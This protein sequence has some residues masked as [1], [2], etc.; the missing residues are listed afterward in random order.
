MKDGIVMY[1]TI[2]LIKEYLHEDYV[3]DVEIIGSG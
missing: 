2:H 3:G 1:Y